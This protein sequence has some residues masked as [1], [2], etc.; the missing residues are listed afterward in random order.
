MPAPTLAAAALLVVAGGLLE[1]LLPGAAQICAHVCIGAAI[2]DLVSRRGKRDG[3][4]IYAAG[5]ERALDR[6]KSFWMR[7]GE[8]P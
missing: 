1:I 3:A 4:T 2:A 5:S 8:H 6:D 7:L